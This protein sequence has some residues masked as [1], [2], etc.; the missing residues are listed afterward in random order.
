MPLKRGETNLG[1]NDERT[2]VHC[3]K[4]SLM[5]KQI[6]I[7][8]LFSVSSLYLLCVVL[9]IMEKRK[10]KQSI[11]IIHD[12]HAKRIKAFRKRGKKN[13]GRGKCYVR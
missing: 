5:H 12:H 11:C 7:S 8:C 13:T 2:G 9:S 10:R 1:H 4:R 6:P 3:A